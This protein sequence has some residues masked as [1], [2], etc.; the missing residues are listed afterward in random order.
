MRHATRK[1]GLLFLVPKNTYHG[2]NAAINGAAGYFVY[3][4]KKK[5]PL[6]ANGTLDI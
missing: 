5:Y 4:R 1:N 6:R 2:D 3:L